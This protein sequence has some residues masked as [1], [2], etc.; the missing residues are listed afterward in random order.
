[1][2]PHVYQIFIRATPEQVWQAITDPAFTEQY[3]HGTR[4]DST[5][6]VGAPVHYRMG[7]EQNGSTDAVEG[8]I[9][10]VDPPRR[11]VHTWRFLYDAGM[12]AEPPSRVEWTVEAAGDG[13]TRL[14]VVHGDLARSPI[15]WSHVSDGWVWILHA[16]KTLLE[17]GEQLPDWTVNVAGSAAASAAD[18][19]GDWHRAQ[20]IE[21]NNSCWEI[22]GNDE[23]TAHDRDE[24]L[25]RA[26]ASAYHWQ[27]AAGRSPATE[28]RARYMIAKA[29]LV[30]GNAELALRSADATLA[31]CIDHGLADFD[32]AYAHEARAR[33]LAMMGRDVEATVA[34]ADARAVPIADPED[35]A[36]V[37]A[38]FAIA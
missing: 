10:E 17:T 32:L 28:A 15:T 18:I 1:M 26:Y 3:F 4:F 6:T 20:A 35:Q 22:I 9:E 24:L 12:A 36:I 2:K 16:M 11:L 34:W 14:R 33:A 25:R 5:L 23:V 29:H 21:C 13:L 37:D 30:A 8:I 19:A 27:R 7:V 31:Q 38:D